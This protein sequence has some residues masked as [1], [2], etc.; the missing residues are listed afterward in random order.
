MEEMSKDEHPIDW[1]FQIEHFK[2]LTHI[3]TTL[4]HYEVVVRKLGRYVY[5]DQLEKILTIAIV[6]LP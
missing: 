1:R 2:E 5:L 6:F 4:N 3:A